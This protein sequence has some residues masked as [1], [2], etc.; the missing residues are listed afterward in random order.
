MSSPSFGVREEWLFLAVRELQLFV[1]SIPP[2]NPFLKS[3]FNSIGA[4]STP[5]E[6]LLRDLLVRLPIIASF[7]ASKAAFHS[8]KVDDTIQ[9]LE[10]KFTEP[11]SVRS[12]ARAVHAKPRALAREFRETVGCPVYRY[13]L[14]KRVAAAIE[15]VLEGR[16][17][18]EAIAASVGFRTKKR[19]YVA[20]RRE[21]GTTPERFR[22]MRLDGAA[23]S[24][25]GAAD[26]S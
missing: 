11:W 23:T 2:A 16:L 18:M 1:A 10:T 8:A 9:L 17:K 13:L 22:R 25:I 15:L 12:L 7:Q 5:L 6:G 21:T 14:R 3:R 26:A 19:F 20:F 24:P 4:P